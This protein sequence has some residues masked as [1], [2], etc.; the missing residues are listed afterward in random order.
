MTDIKISISN[1]VI[2]QIIS[3]RKYI[4]IFDKEYCN[5][6][7]QDGNSL[8]SLAI[9]YLERKQNTILYLFLLMILNYEPGI[10]NIIKN[11]VDINI[12]T[13]KIGYQSKY[14]INIICHGLIG[15]Q[16][17]IY[18]KQN[19][20]RLNYHN[21]NGYVYGNTYGCNSCSRT[22]YSDVFSN[23]MSYYIDDDGSI[24]SLGCRNSDGCY[25][26]EW[27]KCRICDLCEYGL[28]CKSY[29]DNIHSR[30]KKERTHKKNKTYI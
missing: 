12:I 5:K 13:E 9:H 28:Y 23:D 27:T 17:C 18:K 4:D 25:C 16:S 7:L 8:T 11:L 19:N 30:E 15:H 22:S 24:Y 20:D 10:Y 3:T 1:K 14:C 2:K 26:N 21:R 6:F 29:E